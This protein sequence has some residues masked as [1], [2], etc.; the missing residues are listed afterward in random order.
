MVSIYK[1][2]AVFEDI[3]VF[4]KFDMRQIKNVNSPDYKEGDLCRLSIPGGWRRVFFRMHEEGTDTKNIRDWLYN[5]AGM[6]LEEYEPYE[7]NDVIMERPLFYRNCDP[8]TVHSEDID[9]KK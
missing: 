2:V 8:D 6:G 3:E 5:F 7:E 1:D 4:L 9:R